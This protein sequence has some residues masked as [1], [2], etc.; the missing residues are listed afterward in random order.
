MRQVT[1]RLPLALTVAA[2]V[3]TGS[4]CGAVSDTDV[5]ASVGDA[6]LSRSEFEDRLTELGVTDD[7]VLALDP[8]RAEITRW[9]QLELAGRDEIAATYA[10]G[11]AESGVVCVS[12]IVVEDESTAEDVLAELDGGAP[13]ADVFASANRDQS[14]VQTGGAL[15]CLT[16]AD[17]VESADVAFVAVGGELNADDPYGIAPVNDTQGNEAAWVALGFRPFDELSDEDTDAVLSVIGASIDT[18]DVD[19]HVAPRYGVFDPET[20]RVVALG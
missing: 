5:I 11:A 12:A 10:L 7:Q 18:S 15:P 9:I 17:L 8:V 1:R 14:L 3:V 2:L 16:S 4:A 13:F 6:E 20:G 19:V